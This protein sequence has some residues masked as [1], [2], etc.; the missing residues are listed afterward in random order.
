MLGFL[1]RL[2]LVLLLR[3]LHLREWFGFTFLHSLHHGLRAWKYLS[4]ALLEGLRLGNGLESLWL[5][6]LECLLLRLLKCF[7]LKRWLGFRLWEKHILG[8]SRDCEVRL[9]LTLIGWKHLGRLHATCWQFIR[10]KQTGR[11][12][13]VLRALPDI[14]GG[15][16]GWCPN[17]IGDVILIFLRRRKSKCS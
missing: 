2:G 14:C 3:L 9:L 13:W 11:S 16:L 5:L 7:L 10:S 6:L 15:S 8:L 12:T 4:L 17:L 1:E